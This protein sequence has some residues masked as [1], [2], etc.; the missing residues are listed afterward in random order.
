MKIKSMSP[1]SLE[2]S[3]HELAMAI[4]SQAEIYELCAYA[5]NPHHAEYGFQFDFAETVGISMEESHQFCD[6]LC[7]IWNKPDSVSKTMLGRLCDRLRRIWNKL[8]GREPLYGCWNDPAGTIVFTHEEVR[9]IVN[10]IR[11]LLDP[12]SP[13]LEELFTRPGTYESEF[14]A[15]ADRLAAV[16]EEGQAPG[17]GG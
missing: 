10:S 7:R 13:L 16:L 15:F 1:I 9:A 4:S 11:K 6:R 12:R 3:N 8:K 2:L 17:N 14:S 5:S